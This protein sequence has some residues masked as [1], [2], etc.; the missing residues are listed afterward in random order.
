LAPCRKALTVLRWL[1]GLQR[2]VPS[3]PL[4]EVYLVFWSVS[5][6]VEK[7]YQCER[8]KQSRVSSADTGQVVIE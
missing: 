3:A 1:P 8:K 7:L 2:A 4:D 6:S 5:A